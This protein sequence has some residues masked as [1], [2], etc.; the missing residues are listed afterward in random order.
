MRVN[1]NV[2]NGLNKVGQIYLCKNCKFNYTSKKYIA[3]LKRSECDITQNKYYFEC[4]INLYACQ[5]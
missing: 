3:F 1:K 4:R 2:K 5:V